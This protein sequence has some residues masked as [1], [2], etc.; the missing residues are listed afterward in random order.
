MKN[1]LKIAAFTGMMMVSGK[2]YAQTGLDAVRD[3]AKRN[4]DLNTAA[5]TARFNSYMTIAGNLQNI[6][7]NIDSALVS[8]LTTMIKLEMKKHP[9]IE[10]RNDEFYRIRLENMLYFTLNRIYPENPTPVNP[11]M[12]SSPERIIIYPGVIFTRANTPTK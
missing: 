1:L 7:Y 2:F 10:T 3:D 11:G 12:T 8:F 6:L 9:K 5:D 4:L